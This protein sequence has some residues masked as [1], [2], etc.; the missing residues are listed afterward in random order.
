VQIKK[1]IMALQDMNKQ[2]S[3][4]TEADQIVLQTMAHHAFCCECTHPKCVFPWC[5]KNTQSD[6]QFSRSKS[7]EENLIIMKQWIENYAEYCRLSNSSNKRYIKL[8][9]TFPYDSMPQE[10]VDWLRLIMLGDS[11]RTVLAIPVTSGIPP[12]FKYWVIKKIPKMCE[13]D[14]LEVYCKLR[15]VRH[16]SIVS[17][18]WAAMFENHLLVCYAFENV[19]LLDYL[20]GVPSQHLGLGDILNVMLQLTSATSHLHDLGIAYLY[21]ISKNILVEYRPGDGVCVKIC[22]FSCSVFLDNYDGGKL[23]LM[24][25]PAILMPELRDDYLVKLSSDVWGLGCLLNEL[26]TGKQVWHE[27]RHMLDVDLHCLLGENPVPDTPRIYSELQ[28]LFK[29]CWEADWTKRASTSELMELLV[30]TNQN[31]KHPQ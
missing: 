28:C 25:P 7:Q 19:S 18:L 29:A 26:V 16:S 30:E 23:Y 5:G 2:E 8:S 11:R 22:N 17:M 20:R 31:L 15:E 1:S 12:N 4:L 13:W 9:L 27:H 21:W 3:N 24:L 14:H 10:G 6:D